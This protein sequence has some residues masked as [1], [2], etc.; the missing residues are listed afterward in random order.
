MEIIVKGSSKEIAAFVLE[1]Q[2][3]VDAMMDTITR[4]F[5]TINNVADE[6]KEKSPNTAN[7]QA[8]LVAAE[9]VKNII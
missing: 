8:F 9:Q 6:T 3:S 4:S 1:L 5:E 7:E 2:G